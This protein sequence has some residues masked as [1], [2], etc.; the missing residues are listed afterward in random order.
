MSRRIAI[1]QGHPDPNGGH[2]GHALAQSYAE[3]APEGQVMRP[4]FAI[5]KFE[6]GSWKKMLGRAQRAH[7]RHDGNAG[8]HLSLHRMPYAL[9][10]AG[11]RKSGP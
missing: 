2:F 1:I 6:S 7:R 9:Y 5:G 8:V 3:G 11:M 10:Y 4:G